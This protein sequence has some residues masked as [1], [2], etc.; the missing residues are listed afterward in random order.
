MR[1]TVR[2]TTHTLAD[3]ARDLEKVPG[4]IATEGSAI[5]HR[6][7]DRANRITRAIARKKAGPHGENYFKRVT[8]DMV[9]PLKVE[10]GPSALLGTRYVGVGGTAGVNRDLEEALTK[11]TPQFVRD[12]EKF[13]DGLL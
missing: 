12:A 3:A 7:G 11:V 1:I 4:K 13:M 10:V 8:A 9:T 5:V 6:N 2:R